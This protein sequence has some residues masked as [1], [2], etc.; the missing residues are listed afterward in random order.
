MP[1]AAPTRHA[2]L[3][4]VG[5]DGDIFPFL[6]LGRILRARGHRVTLATHEHFASRAAAAGLEFCAL[7]SNAETEDLLARASLW[8]P[9]RGPQTIAAWGRP[10]MRRHHAELRRSIAFGNASLIANPGVVAARLLAEERSIPLTSVV[11]QPWIIQSIHAPPAMMGGLSLPQGMPRVLGRA[12]YRA[13]DAM[14]W[15]LVGRELNRL[16]SSLGMA[17]VRRVFQ[18][19]LSPSLVLGLFP[20]WY[21]PPQAD[22]PPHLRLAGFPLGDSRDDAGLPEDVRTLCAQ[23]RPTV[24]LTFG[25]GMKHSARLFAECIEACRRGGWNGI[26]LSQFR[27]QLPATLPA[28]VRHCGFASFESLFPLCRAV[29]HHG[30]IGTTSKA[31][32]AGI[33]Q[34]ILPFAF[35]Q[36]DNA[37]R[38]MR[39]GVGTWLT[40]SHRGAGPLVEALKEVLALEIQS[41][42][43]AIADR[44][45]GGDGLRNAVDQIEEFWR[46]DAGPMVQK[47]RLVDGRPS[48]G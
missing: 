44:F 13:F 19:W 42:A 26:L 4:T 5:T 41:R 9:I 24:A 16:R 20:D 22:W 48:G 33:G 11:L 36:L 47:A 38:V 17:P 39:L 23:E 45:E 25:T 40:R 29:V 37:K 30:G 6:G 10:M 46:S 27:D 7:V 35:D 8:N 3:A 15:F 32:R 43:R 1:E 34:L 21:G 28:F 12:Y 31:L 14:G 18:W 2:V